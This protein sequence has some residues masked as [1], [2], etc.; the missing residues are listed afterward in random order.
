MEGKEITI[1][2]KNIIFIGCRNY[3]RS[4]KVYQDLAESHNDIKKME[5]FLKN[6]LLWKDKCD[7]PTIFLDSDA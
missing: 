3:S 6:E 5:E 1:M 7:K 2:Q 4:K